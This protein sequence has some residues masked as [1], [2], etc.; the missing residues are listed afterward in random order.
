MTHSY[1]QPKHIQIHH[2]IAIVLKSQIISVLFI[3]FC[4]FL[5]HSQV[6]KDSLLAT[7]NN[8]TNTNEKRA[9]AYNRLITTYYVNSNLDSAYA[10]TKNLEKFVLKNKLKLRQGD[11]FITYGNIEN[12]LGNFPNSTNMYVKALAIYREIEDKKGLAV[13]LNNIGRSY[14]Y[15]WNFD[16]ALEYYQKS[17]KINTVL[18]DSLQIA[19][20][21]SN[22]G[23]I[24]ANRF[25][26]EEARN[27]YHKSIEISTN[28][29]DLDGKATTLIN[30]GATYLFKTEYPKGVEIIKEGL[31]LSRELKNLN[32][33]CNALHMLTGHFFNQEQYDIA[34]NYGN[35]CLEVANKLSNTLIIKNA[36]TLLYEAYKNKGDYK[37]ALGYL[38][39]TNSFNNKIEDIKMSQQL[40]KLEIDRVRMVDSLNQEKETIKTSLMHQAEIQQKNTEKRN[41]TIGFVSLLFGV[42]V[43]TF[44]IYKNTKR[45]QLI[46]EQDKE[47][48]IQKKEKILKELE[49]NAI[50]AM[51]EGQE[52]ER[53]LLASDL[54]DS[55]G[56]SLAAARLQFNHIANNKD[57][58]EHL[59]ELIKKTS[60]LLEDAYVEVRSLAHKKT[61]G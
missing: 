1:K 7:W 52:K 47:I 18:K 31:N 34:I 42:T 53:Q 13:A 44:L 40:Q 35:Q 16:K 43:I 39:E 48:E 49:L 58:I 20:N 37:K 28:I 33:E 10:M 51:I 46:A 11:V 24:F 15:Q 38:E 57:H 59:D 29:N 2:R 45:K 26:Q 27:Y 55:V 22:I 41:L 6:T 30:L 5:T 50:D 19:T 17:L 25:K 3:L 36:N 60:T 21:L 32:V 12:V 8:T 54:H 61:M 4:S 23:N 9:D 56:A 14:K